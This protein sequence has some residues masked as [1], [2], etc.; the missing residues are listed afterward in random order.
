MI[1]NCQ[2]Y[3]YIFLIFLFALRL[4]GISQSEFVL[5]S[6]NLSQADTTWIFSPIQSQEFN[7]AKFPIV[8]LLHGYGGNFRQ[9]NKITDLQKLANKY[10]C[11]IACPDGLKD[12]WYFNSPLR[13]N[14]QYESFFIEEYLPYLKENFKLDTNGI[15][16]SGLS[17]GGHGAMYLF[18]KHPQLFASA[19]SSSG[20]LD[21]NAS[22][23]KY[24]SLSDQLGE[25]ERNEARFN[26][27]SSIHLL[28]N[29]KFSEKPI[30]FDCGNKDHLYAATQKFK[31]TCD[32][33]YINAFYF[34][35]PGRH[36]SSYWKESILWHFE[37]FSRVYQNNKY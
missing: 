33:L 10:S 16:I 35:F 5:S 6:N 15:F 37:F 26:A 12:S 31:E 8:I 2:L 3:V 36:N 7:N 11:Y 29:I 30:I 9:W 17:M 13:A 34:S 23:L 14:S 32:S 1:K 22:S 19:G 28:E 18:L 20:T 27:Y 4:N 21:L 24:T 25:Y